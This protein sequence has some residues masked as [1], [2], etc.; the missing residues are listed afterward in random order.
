[1]SWINSPLRAAIVGA[2]TSAPLGVVAHRYKARPFKYESDAQAA[3]FAAVLGA[4]SGV[5]WYWGIERAIYNQLGAEK[6]EPEPDAVLAVSQLLDTDA[7]EMPP[8]CRN[9]HFA[10]SGAYLNYYGVAALRPGQ[11]PVHSMMYLATWRGNMNTN[12]QRFATEAALR[13]FWGGFFPNGIWAM[14]TNCNADFCS[15]RVTR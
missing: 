4:L 3:G 12:A 1:M 14:G 8:G 10:C 9:T 13:T 11:N 7:P 5:A 6:H 2:V 15:Y